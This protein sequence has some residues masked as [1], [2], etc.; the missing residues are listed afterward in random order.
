M[1]TVNHAKGMASRMEP[2]VTTTTNSKVRTRISRTLARI[3][4]SQA[5]GP[6]PKVRRSRYEGDNNKTAATTQAANNSKTGGRPG[7]ASKTR[8]R[9]DIA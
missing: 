3:R 8:Y 6:A 2:P 7:F 5:S 9:I 1:R 4:R